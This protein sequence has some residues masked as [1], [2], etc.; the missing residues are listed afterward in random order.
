[1]YDVITAIIITILFFLGGIFLLPVIKEAIRDNKWDKLIE[2][3]PTIKENFI[4]ACGAIEEMLS[5]QARKNTLKNEIEELTSV[6]NCLTDD[7][8]KKDIIEG[9]NRRKKEY[10]VLME[11]Y[12]TAKQVEEKAHTTMVYELEKLGLY[13]EYKDYLGS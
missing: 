3:N 5:I 13:E 2:S 6:C 10:S 7:Y 9:I 12:Q 11:Q 4:A 8:D 1:M